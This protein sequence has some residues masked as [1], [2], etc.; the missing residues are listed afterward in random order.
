MLKSCRFVL[1]YATPE[2]VCFVDL[3]I[4]SITT[5]VAIA[6]YTISY[7]LNYRYSTTCKCIELII[8]SY[9]GMVDIYKNYMIRVVKTL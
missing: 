2:R 8:I 9:H 6:I 5:T 3:V 1:P 4:T 7:M